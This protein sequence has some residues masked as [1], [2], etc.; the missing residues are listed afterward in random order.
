MRRKR[1]SNSKGWVLPSDGVVPS[2]RKRELLTQGVFVA[3]TTTDAVFSHAVSIEPDALAAL[4]TTAVESLDFELWS[5]VEKCAAGFDLAALPELEFRF[6]WGR[7][8][9]YEANGQP[10]EALESARAVSRFARSEAS[11]LL[12]RCRRASVLLRYGEQLAYRDLASSIRRRFEALEPSGVRD[13]AT[14]MLPLEVAEM[15]GLMGDPE[16]AEYA[17]RSRPAGR[18]L[19]PMRGT[20]GAARYAMDAYAE[21]IVADAAGGSLRAQRSY[22]RAFETYRGIG[23]TRRAMSAALRLAEMT[24]DE[25]YSAFVDE[26]AQRLSPRSWIRSTLAATGVQRRD[27]ALLRLSRAEREVL[28]YLVAGHSTAHIAAVRNRSAQTTRNS[29]SKLLAAFGVASRAELLREV[30]QRRLLDADG[31]PTWHVAARST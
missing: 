11:N 9:L 4:S 30:R 10:E 24:G 19:P 1:R 21:A 8:T 16:G 31:A 17:L 20:E 28:A 29:I 5:F 26:H 7:S 15:L 18:D 13:W 27:P 25:A 14:A 23:F 3:R 2:R 12:G 6:H 22:R